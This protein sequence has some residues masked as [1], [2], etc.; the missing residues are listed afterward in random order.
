MGIILN[1]C[2]WHN[3]LYKNGKIQYLPRLDIAE[4]CY[5]Y[6]KRIADKQGIKIYNATRGGNLE[7]FERIELDSVVPKQ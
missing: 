2:N 5:E 4:E 1:Q 6:C 3:D 7:T